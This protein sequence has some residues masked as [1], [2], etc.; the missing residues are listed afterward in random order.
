MQREVL[1][2]GMLPLD[3]NDFAIVSRIRLGFFEVDS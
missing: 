2:D 3:E 1:V